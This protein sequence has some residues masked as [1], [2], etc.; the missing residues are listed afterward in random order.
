MKKYFL[1]IFFAAISTGCYAQPSF[2]VLKTF[3]IASGG[4]WDYLAVQPNS[5][6]LF[7][8]HGTQVNILDKTNGDSIG[9]IPKTI[10][11]HGIAFVSSLNKGYVSNGKLNNV[12]VFDLTTFAVK[13][14][15]ATGQNPD[16]IFY[17]EYSK[18]IITCNGRSKDV[19]FI[20]PVTDKVTATVFVGGRPETAVSNGAGKIFINLED[21]NQV[22][23]IDANTLKVVAN[24]PLLP[25]EAPTGLAIDTETKRL[26]VACGDNNLLV[27]LDAEKG[28]IIDKLPIGGHCDGAAFDAAL[29][30]IYTSNGEGTVSVIHEDSKDKF[31]L[32]ATV[33]TKK[34]ARTI[35]V[36]EKTHLLYL[37][38]ADFEPAKGEERP[39]M[40]PGTFQ[41]LV[42][43]E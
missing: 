23:V 41:V 5:N 7:V 20:D 13:D 31:T 19:T 40:I 24:W 36:D 34:G 15:I 32:T 39:K 4:G 30:N 43:G 28:T 6:R 3:K 12:T 10:G 8:S 27:I 2:K 18:R 33:P 16:A 9:V 38:T 21:K 14:S 42:V 26:F 35:S 11:V 17:D 22:A 37:S 29:K 25:G 1:I